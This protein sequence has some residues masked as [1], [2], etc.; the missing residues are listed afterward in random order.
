VAAPS[1][2]LRVRVA[3]GARSSAIVGRH[4]DGW[5][6][7]VSA[8]PER[9]RAND[10]VVGVI[11]HALGVERKNVKLIGGAAGRDKVFEL[12]GLSQAEA[13]RRLAQAGGTP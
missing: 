13:D 4:G 12:T 6:V 8:P 3:P 1:T 7:R 11:A 10:A 5:K 2:R 9:G